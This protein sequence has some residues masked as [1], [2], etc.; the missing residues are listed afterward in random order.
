MNLVTAIR[1][2]A[3]IIASEDCTATSARRD[4]SE[5]TRP[6]EL[7]S[8]YFSGADDVCQIVPERLREFLTRWMIEH[9]PADFPVESVLGSLE[10]FFGWIQST[11]SADFSRHLSMISELRPAI[12]K[13]DKLGTAL[14][15]SVRAR[16]FGF[17]EFLTS[18]EDG[19]RSLYDIDEPGKTGGA[20]SVD[21][22]F[23]VIRV[24][25]SEVEAEETISGERFWPIDFPFESLSLVAPQYVI[26]LALIRVGDRWKIY[27]SGFAYPPQ[28]DV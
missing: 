3:R 16:G 25:G 12:V 19:G 14:S 23:R 13:A 27:E 9:R 22:L 10:Q 5:S 1:E 17:P 8:S 18:F 4:V 11:G 6:L 7:L 20:G 15:K 26:N 21:G 2:F 28:A 24:E